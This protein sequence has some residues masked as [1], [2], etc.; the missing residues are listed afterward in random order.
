M[1]AYEVPSF[2]FPD[3]PQMS[4]EMLG[5]IERMSRDALAN[6]ASRTRRPGVEVTPVLRQGV[7]WTEI[8]ELAK[9]IDAG[10]IVMGTHGRRGFARMMMG[11]VAERVVRT[12]P[13]PVLTVHGPANAS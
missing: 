8:G 11:S 7:A 3:G 4:V 9:E 2:G 1:H 5:T 6:I 10:L 13:C 12:A